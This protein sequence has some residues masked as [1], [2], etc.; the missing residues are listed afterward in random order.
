[1]V[2]ISPQWCMFTVGIVTWLASGL[3]LAGVTSYS[4]EIRFC[5]ELDAQND[6]KIINHYI[7]SV[8][9]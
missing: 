4:A 7:N 8:A 6:V 5:G 9:R 1:M 2:A 3:L